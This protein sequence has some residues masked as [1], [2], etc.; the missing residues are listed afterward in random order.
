MK[1]KNH[2]YDII[3][4]GAGAA[5]LMAAITA[6][7]KGCR[8]LV[9]DHHTEPAK[10]LLATGNGKCNFTNKMQGSSY[11]RGGNPAFVLN[12]LH[13]FSAE[14]TVDFFA[15]LGVLS[16]EK[17]GYYYPRSGQASAIRNAL[18]L[19]AKRNQ[20]QILS[21]IGIRMIRKEQDIFCL[22]TKSGNFY[23]E[24]CILATGGK[25]S[26]KTGSDGSGYIYAKKLGHSI[27][28]PLPALTA[29]VAKE[30][31]MKK[32]AGVRADAAVTLFVEGKQIVSDTGELQMTDYGVSGIPI[33]QISRFASIALSEGKEVQVSIDF[34]PEWKR[35]EISSRLAQLAV[36]NP[37]FQ[38]WIEIL[39][40]FV[41]QKIAG[42]IAELAN[43]SLKEGR[44]DKGLCQKQ[45]DRLSTLLKDTRISILQARGF[46]HAQVTCGGIPVSELKDGT[47][48]SNLVPGLYFAGEMVD[49]DGICGGYNLQWAWSS[50]YAAGI[51]A[52]EDRI[53][54]QVTKNA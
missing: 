34:L 25:A 41:N 13:Q 48:E 7:R 31:W 24:K 46:D 12:I 33:F 10:K 15:G 8:V 44:M 37:G 26:P 23:S 19:E 40:G 38:N 2:L 36:S 30:A 52:A 17:Q 27:K 14:D 6:A 32:T 4:V 29:L 54:R 16:R 47:M 53:H 21:E 28:M 3:V 42:V 5:G 39:S 22:E 11:Y 51:H 49:V 35:E 18:L 9:L 45:A 20:V 50:G 1:R 43:G